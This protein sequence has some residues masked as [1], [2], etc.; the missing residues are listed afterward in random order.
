MNP[1]G[2]AMARRPLPARRT[3]AAAIFSDLQY[4]SFA[5]GLDAGRPLCRRPCRTVSA[6][7]PLILE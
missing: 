1:P 2:R 7:D 4:T 5:G 3:I 6:L